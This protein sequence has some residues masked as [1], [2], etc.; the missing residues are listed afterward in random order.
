MKPSI[1]AVDQAPVI[2]LPWQSLGSLYLP[3]L[4]STADWPDTSLGS[5]HRDID[6]KSLP[7]DPPPALMLFARDQAPDQRCTAGNSTPHL[8]WAV[9]VHP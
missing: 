4:L 6:Y 9:P 2:G 8:H 3:Q 5:A 1:T 7:D